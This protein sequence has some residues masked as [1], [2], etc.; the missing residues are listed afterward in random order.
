MRIRALA[1]SWGTAAVAAL[2]ALAPG[3]VLAQTTTAEGLGSFG[4]QAELDAFILARRPPPPE[5]VEIVVSEPGPAEPIQDLQ[6]DG[7]G[8]PADVQRIGDHLV[9]LRGGRLH[10]I[11]IADGRLAEVASV[12]VAPDE[13]QGF[14]FDQML[15]FRDQVLVFGDASDDEV[16]EPL[17]AVARYRLGRGG[18]LALRDISH[19]ALGQAYPPRLVDGRLIFDSGSVDDGLGSP[20]MLPSIR[21]WT[22]AAP[23][24]PFVSFLRPDDAFVRTRLRREQGEPFGWRMAVT[25]CDLTTARLDCRATLLLNPSGT[26]QADL[27]EEAAYFWASGGVDETAVLFRVPLD[28]GQP[29]AVQVRGNPVSPLSIREQAGR[30]QA[31]VEAPTY[32]DPDWDPRFGEGRL[33][34]LTLP[35]GRFGSGSGEA[36]KRDYRLLSPFPGE[37]RRFVRRIGDHLLYSSNNGDGGWDRGPASLIVAD[38]RDGREQTFT[39]DGPITRLDAVGND[40]LIVSGREGATFT[41]LSLGREAVAVDF[42]GPADDAVEAWTLIQRPEGRGALL[43]VAVA[44]DLDPDEAAEDYVADMLF[45]SADRGGLSNAGELAARRDLPRERGC[46]EWCEGRFAN[47]RA[48]FIGDRIFALLGYELIEGRLEDG[49]VREVGRLDFAPPATAGGEGQ[50]D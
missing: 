10:V 6:R 36:L 4:S 50:G 37:G 13:A 23:D 1:I 30:L 41:S 22:A 47:S 9:I 19:L 39:F 12:E 35:F 5:E 42:T 49:R 14:R 28:G 16:R 46:D 11:S 3:A 38:L 43:G 8:T 48:I 26:S 2:L 29:Q 34:V 27:S 25:R 21:T 24:A 31:V 44:R 15:V 18:Q 7:V 32:E 20:P 17:V 33:A 45:L 40:A